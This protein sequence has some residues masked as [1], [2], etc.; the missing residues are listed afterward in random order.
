ML[1]VS[2]YGLDTAQY[3]STYQKVKWKDCSLREWLN[4]GFRNGAF[5]NVENSVIGDS[6]RVSIPTVD[7]FNQ[8][9]ITP[10]TKECQAG[11]FAVANH[12]DTS[13]SGNCRWWLAS[14]V[15]SKSAPYVDYDGSQKSGKR[16][17]YED[18][19]IRPVIWIN[20]ET[21]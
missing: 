2:K 21:S 20:I 6:V 10:N 18:F 16:V 15:L 4:T 17:D 5:T 14:S 19:C 7:Q 13:K 1:I 8:Y 9:F 11:M 3:N 12:A